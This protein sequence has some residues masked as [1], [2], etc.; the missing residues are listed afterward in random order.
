[1][2]KVNPPIEVTDE[3][4]AAEAAIRANGGSLTAEEW[5]QTQDWERTGWTSS[6]TQALRMAG[7]DGAIFGSPGSWH[8]CRPRT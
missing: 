5:Q 7:A 6:R 3:A 1:M 2:A 8:V 4:R